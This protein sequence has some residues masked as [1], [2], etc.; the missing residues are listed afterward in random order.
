MLSFELVCLGG[1]GKR[2]KVRFR[3]F[4]GFGIKLHC[5]L[6]S[7]STWVMLLGP[8]KLDQIMP[9]EHVHSKKAKRS[10]NLGRS[11]TK[12]SLHQMPRARLPWR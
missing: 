1:E 2:E 9:L 6:R 11:Q 10:D 5:W 4:D 8:S 3:A 12:A 7:L